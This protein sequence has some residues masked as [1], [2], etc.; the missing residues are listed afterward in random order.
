M[1]QKQ[2]IVFLL[3]VVGLLV[4]PLVLQSFGNAW[5]RIA[6][7]ALLYV[8]LAL[9]LNIVV[10]YAGLLDLG[11]VAFFAIG[12]YM[13]ALLAS[14]HLTENFPAIAAMF[15]DGLH[16]PIWV[17][18]PASAGLAAL[19]GVL[20]G[21]PTLRL[22]GDYLA[23]VT[24]GFGEIIRVFM[25]NLD[26]PVNITNGPKGMGEID[27]LTFFG[28]SFGKR[29]DIFGYDISSVTLYYYLFLVLVV[30][31]VVISHRLQLSRVGR[32]WMAIREDEIAAKAMGINT[33]NLKLLAF[34]MGATFGGVSGAM[35]ASFQ[36][37]ISPESFSLMESVM[38][39]AMVVLG[40]IGHLPGVILGAVALSA[41]PEVLRY[42]AGP[43]QSMTGGRLDA[44]ILRQLLIALAMISIMLLRPRGL[45]P[46]PEHGKSL[47]STKP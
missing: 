47:T 35:F 26:H 44:S 19:F 39:V 11:Y 18:I 15:P 42:V 37:F 7:M 31:S 25:N 5:V 13:Y 24:L 9:G 22:R 28:M 30:F 38:I 16:M 33:R 3:A 23:I 41:M 6:D 12:A 40:G 1:K 46:A 32:A 34:G 8:L 14:P 27:S 36:G 29:I 43:L 2:I 10:G 21:A 17:I 20:L 45:W 4:T